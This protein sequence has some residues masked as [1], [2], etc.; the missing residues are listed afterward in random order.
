VT[1]PR[2][3]ERQ[4][5]QIVLREFGR[6]YAEEVGI[7]VEKNIPSALFQLLYTA[8]LLSARIAAGNAVEAARALRAAGLTTP[9]KMAAASWQDRVDVITWHGYKRYDEKTSTMLGQ[10]ADLVLDR[11]HGDL[12]RLRE[13]AQHDVASEKERLKEFKGIGDVGADIF[14]R[15]IQTTWEEAYPYA[16][17]KV[18]EAATKLGLPG[19]A[20]SLAELVP[21]D[22]FAQFAAGLI[23][24]AI[25]KHY[26]AVRAA[27]ADG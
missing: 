12:R 14:L 5:A 18:L 11:Y 6:T 16:D 22:R 24:I 21:R 27:V 7:A 8:L 23:R 15:E 10:S 9:R 4:L 13:Q 20:A 25:G 1:V 2:Q 3:T 26:E 17:R 19:D